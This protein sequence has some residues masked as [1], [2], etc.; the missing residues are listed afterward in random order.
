MA[1]A[2]VARDIHLP[3]NGEM[4]VTEEVI[5]Y[6]CVMPTFLGVQHRLRLIRTEKTASLC[7]EI[8]EITKKGFTEM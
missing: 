6:L 7:V 3:P 1:D 8:R 2:Y 5:V 4:N